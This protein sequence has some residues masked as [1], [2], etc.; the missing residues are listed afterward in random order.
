MIVDKIISAGL[1]TIW[2]GRTIATGILLN[3]G[4]TFGFATVYRDSSFIQFHLDQL[5]SFRL[6]GLLIWTITSIPAG[7]LTGTIVNKP[8]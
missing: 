4:V 3:I 7:R 1:L 2:Q 6:P 8:V 5:T